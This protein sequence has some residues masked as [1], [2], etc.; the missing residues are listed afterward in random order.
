MLSLPKV[1]I[2]SLSD[3]LIADLRSD[4][5]GETGAVAIYRG[6]LAISRDAEVRAFAEHHLA[7][8]RLHLAVFEQWLPRRMQSRLLPLW[9]VS[10]WLLGAIAALGSKRF[11]YLTIAAVETFVIEHYEAQLAYAPDAIQ[12]LLCSLQ[13]DERAH[14]DD[15]AD[16]FAGQPADL[17][18][19]L[20]RCWHSII[21]AGSRWAVGAARHV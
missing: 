12:P 19:L 6:M 2:A 7:T 4:H 21:G 20:E 8:E 3:E 5:A 15:A 9:H 13:A 16:R 14:R 1:P 11:T 17:A 10:G 18:G